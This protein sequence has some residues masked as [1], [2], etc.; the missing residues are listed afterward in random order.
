MK[1]SQTIDLI[2]KERNI[3]RR[4]V[5]TEIP[6][7]LFFLVQTH[8]GAGFNRFYQT[9]CSWR[10]KQAQVH[11]IQLPQDHD[12]ASQATRVKESCWQFAKWKWYSG[13]IK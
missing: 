5:G 1:G 6:T 8:H 3:E 9:S 12:V 10:W 7:F 13:K 4:I 11:P 2:W